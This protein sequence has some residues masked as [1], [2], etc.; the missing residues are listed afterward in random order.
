MNPNASQTSSWAYQ[1]QQQQP[2]PPEWLSFVDK[3]TYASVAVAE[4]INAII[5]KGGDALY[6]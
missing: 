2:A 4:V 3:S 6:D 5:D 1:Q